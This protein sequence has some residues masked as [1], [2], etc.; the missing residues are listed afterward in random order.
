[1]SLRIRAMRAR[2]AFALGLTLAASLAAIPTTAYAG[3]D[4]DPKTGVRE[5]SLSKALGDKAPDADLRR[6]LIE[7]GVA[8]QFI[9]NVDGLANTRGGMKRGATF[10]GRLEF[11]LDADLEKLMSWQGATFHTHMFDI[12]GAGLS[13]KFVGNMMPVSNI[14]AVPTFR[15]FELWIEQKFGDSFSIKVGQ[16]GVD[17]EHAT[18]SYAGL[19]NNGT[20]GWPAILGANLPSGGPAFPLA[21]P[22]VRARYEF[23]KNTSWLVAVFN[24]DPAKPGLGDPQ[25]RNPH[26]VDFRWRHGAYVVTEAQH[27]YNQEKDAAGL[28]GS[29]KLGVW[30]HLARFDDQRW[31]TDNLSLANPASNGIARRHNGNYGV[32]GMLDQMVWRLEGDKGVGIFAR[33]FANPSDRNPRRLADRRRNCRQRPHRRASRRC[34]RPRRLLR[35]HFRPRPR[36]GRRRCVVRRGD[37]PPRL[38]GHRR[39]Q[40]SMAGHARLDASAQRPV[41]FPPRRPCRQPGG[42]GRQTDQE[43]ACRRPALGMEMVRRLRF[44]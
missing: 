27:K 13:R 26:G 17:G 31:G 21:T 36:A 35:P 34:F 5:Q 20:F 33:A 12:Q 38:R 1:M 29:I 8:Y 41:H 42:P 37:V 11:N 28:P 40:L 24:G 7:K 9:Y 16:I 32:Y 6:A 14:E 4:P 10:S 22:A 43:C 44:S 15:L 39:G 3:D 25:I 30:R 23:T 19:F 2:P 18:S